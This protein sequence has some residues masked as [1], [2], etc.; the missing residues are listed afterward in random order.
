MIKIPHFERHTKNMTKLGFF[1]CGMVV[2]S[3]VFMSVHNHNFNL[4][5]EKYQEVE[6]E[7]TELK[8]ELA[9]LNK[10]RTKQAIISK[11]H[12]RII[13][14]ENDPPI[15]EVLE[16]EMETNV[17]N[18]LKLY[19]GQ[20]VTKLSTLEDQKI[21]QGLINKRF[22]INNTDYVMETKSF[23]LIHSELTV[24]VTAKPFVPPR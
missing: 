9:T 15:D 16:N 3:A 17:R 2:G 18:A 12:V 14:K 23:V 4:L 24:W 13:P 7:N 22:F 21:A 8:D 1:I 20:P 5:Y 19:I 6:S 11:I 10:Y